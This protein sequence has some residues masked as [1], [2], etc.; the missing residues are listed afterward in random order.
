MRKT[1]LLLAF[2]V[3]AF[4]AQ[5][6]PIRAR[7]VPNAPILLEVYSDYQCPACKALYERT[8]FPLMFDY[9]ERGKTYLIHNE[10]PITQLHLHSQE[11][12]CYALA[13]NRVGK[14]M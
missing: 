6:A 4:G 3:A 11:S 14:Y 9:V 13:S 5:T 10:F 12:S 1:I 2:L 7:G 8:L